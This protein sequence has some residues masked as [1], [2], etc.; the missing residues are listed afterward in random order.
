M[1]ALFL[2][3]I[4]T[5]FLFTVTASSRHGFTA[6]LLHRRLSSYS[7]SSSLVSIN[8]QLGSSPYAD[9]FYDSSL[10]VYVMKLQIG[11]PPIE[12]EAILDTG[13]ELLW[14]QCLPC[15]NC[16]NQK[17]PIFDPSK[18]SSFKEKRCHGHSCPYETVTIHSTSG[19]PFVMAETTFGCGHNNSWFGGDKPSASGVVGLDWISSSLVSQM[20]ENYLGLLSY[21]LAGKGT[22]KINFGGNAIVAGDGTVSATMFIKP[23]E[24]GNFYLNLDAISV[25]ENRVETLGT[26]FQALDGNIVIDSGTLYT[27]LP[28]SYCNKVK[29]AVEDVVTADRIQVEV[30]QNMLCY[31][32]DTTDMFPVITFH[33]SG[34]ADLVLDKY[35]MYVE[36]V[37]GTFCLAIVCNSDPTKRAFFGSRAQNNLLVGYD[38]SSQLVSFKPTDCSA[39]WS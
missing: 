38:P 22:S 32:S 11:T 13:S 33:F 18:S 21:C 24:S 2:Q 28:E 3:I 25:G 26:P 17:A 36:Y 37:P 35:N 10:F 12:I 6:D 7:S 16:Y 30:M 4:I 19:E 39:L 5:C 8:T 34:G 29:E 27:Y 1:F 15:L 9:T 31:N 20:G 23:K 14:I